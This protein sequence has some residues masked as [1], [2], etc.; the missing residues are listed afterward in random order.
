[1]KF[2]VLHMRRVRVLNE[3]A[4][5]AG[6]GGRLAVKSAHDRERVRALYQRFVR[7]AGRGKASGT[8]R[9]LA[10]EVHGPTCSVRRG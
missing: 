6:R 10:G 3:T 2:W 4:E 1:M 5:E 8:G 7:I 9:S